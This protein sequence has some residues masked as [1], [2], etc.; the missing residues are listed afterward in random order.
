M[1]DSHFY[2]FSYPDPAVWKQNVL[3]ELTKKFSGENLDKLIHNYEVNPPFYGLSDR[4]TLLDRSIHNQ[5]QFSI[6]SPILSAHDAPDL[7]AQRAR[8]GMDGFIIE[9]GLSPLRLELLSAT[10][11][12]NSELYFHF[13]R[14]EGLSDFLSQGLDSLPLETSGG[15]RWNMFAPIADRK[16]SFGDLAINPLIPEVY[17]KTKK[18][19]GFRGLSFECG[20]GGDSEEQMIHQLYRVLSEF[21]EVLDVLTEQGEEVRTVLSATAFYVGIGNDYF[22]EIIRIRLLKKMVLLLARDIDSTVS[23]SDIFIFCKS[24][25]KP[26][27]ASELGEYLVRQTMKGM[28]A[29]QGGCDALCL[30][31]VSLGDDLEEQCRLLVNSAHIIRHETGLLRMEDPLWGNFYMTHK[32]SE[33]ANKVL[34]LLREG[35]R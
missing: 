13:T 20:E 27:S 19:L 8:W 15:L 7:L 12:S 24:E 23:A 10:Y 26:L 5:N 32:E 4:P 29:T 17:A 1:I 11:R 22:K 30:G 16:P 18:F 21:I 25:D 33:W 3:N 28:M 9:E 34:V 6:I 31:A 2:G 14:P 35:N